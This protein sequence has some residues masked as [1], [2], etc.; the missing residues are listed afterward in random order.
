MHEP[1]TTSQ[2]RASVRLRSRASLRDAA[3]P[4]VF[5]SAVFARSAFNFLCDSVTLWSV[6]LRVFVAFVFFV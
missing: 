6:F 4:F 3:E 2:A 5:R 1:N